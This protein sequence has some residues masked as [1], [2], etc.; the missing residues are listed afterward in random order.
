MH[1]I[2]FYWLLFQ[3]LGG[4][5]KG[6]IC[7]FEATSNLFQSPLYTRFSLIPQFS[8]IHEPCCFFGFRLLPCTWPT[9]RFCLAFLEYVQRVNVHIMNLIS[10]LHILTWTTKY[11]EASQFAKQGHVVCSRFQPHNYWEVLLS[12]FNLKLQFFSINPANISNEHY[13]IV[14]LSLG[15]GSHKIIQHQ[16]V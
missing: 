9:D 13:F 4:G 8:N 15:K 5:R 10:S 16:L 6:H 1:A 11:L 2:F 12:Y 3:S 7:A 14:Q